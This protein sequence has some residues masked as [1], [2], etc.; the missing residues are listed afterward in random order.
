[1]PNVSVQPNF[2]ATLLKRIKEKGYA[3]IQKFYVA[4]DAYY[5]PYRSEIKQRKK[6]EEG[7]RG[8]SEDTLHRY[9]YKFDPHKNK[10]NSGILFHLAKFLE[11]D[12]SDLVLEDSLDNQTQLLSSDESVTI[13]AEVNPM[14]A[15]AHTK[16][17]ATYMARK[18]QNFVGRRHVYTA[19]S[20]FMNSHDRGYF[21]VVGDPGEGKSAIA[22]HYVRMHPCLFYFNWR[23]GELTTP[24][25]FLQCLCNQA[26]EAGALEA[27]WPDDATDNGL[28]LAELLENYARKVGKVV[29]VVD[30][31]DEAEH[32][33]KAK[34]LYLPDENL[35]A[36]VYFFLTTRRDEKLF[37]R[38]PRHAPLERYD[39]SHYKQQCQDDL[40]DYYNSFIHDPAKGAYRREQ[41]AKQSQ[42][43][44]SFGEALIIKSKRNF[45][46]M[47]LVLPEIV[48]GR[49][50]G[51][52]IDKLPSGLFKYYEE[53]WYYMLDVLEELG[54]PLDTLSI[55]YYICESEIALPIDL[56]VKRSSQ[57]KL[58][59]QWILHHW[60]QFLDPE[61]KYQKQRYTF[62]HESYKDHLRR[63]EMI[64][65]A[66]NVDLREIN[67]EI[68]MS[69]LGGF[70]FS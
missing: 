31:L 27:P 52:E 69:M 32:K 5:D 51:L 19:F 14:L 17:F 39:L 13:S 12:W 66:G 49:Y 15:S 8:S 4:F 65:S 60:L 36:N 47:T 23:G 59:V 68:G 10:A 37:G 50:R 11:L 46:Y 57:K 56:I 24:K 55:V 33:S 21:T 70:R 18:L 42:T 29:I 63:N 35:P 2:S 34:L 38:L 58:A 44:E 40:R 20:D 7:A 28:F 48:Q 61:E 30:A 6:K 43:L 45:M 54:L 53:H 41:L 67:N 22:A 64:Q 1:M 9:L 26:I 25:Q 16:K 3:P 62:Y